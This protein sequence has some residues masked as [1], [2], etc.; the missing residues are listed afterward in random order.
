[1]KNT[2]M[3]YGTGMKNQFKKQIEEMI[4]EGYISKRRHPE[5]DLYILNYTK[6]CQ[7]NW[8][9]NEATMTCRGLIV[10]EN[11]DVIARPFKKFFTM[12]QWRDLRSGFKHLTGLK[13]KTAFD[14]PFTVTEKMD[15]SLGVLF[16]NP[17][18][19]KWELSSR[20]SFESDQ[21]IRANKILKK[22]NTTLLDPS[23]TYMT[24]IVYPTNR[25]VVDYGEREMLC[26]LT[27]FHLKDG[28]EDMSVAVEDAVLANMPIAKKYSFSSF[29][30]IL[31]I[32]EDEG[33]GFVVRFDNGLR[34]KVKFEEYKRLHR[35]MTGITTP[36]KVW[37]MLLEEMDLDEV[38]KD[39]PVE[40]ADSIME[41]ANGLKE[42]YWTIYDHVK[43]IIVK[44]LV[45][46][47][48]PM[49]RKQ[50]ALK[51][52]DYKYKGVMFAILDNKEY[53]QTIWRLIRPEAH[54]HV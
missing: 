44:E 13:Y 16:W 54:Q 27:S 50:M 25:I 46:K 9:W 43:S 24:E 22:Y 48:R 26:M 52:Q 15:G 36:R 20:G 5:C 11:W 17:F 32:Q 40:F 51:Y 42:E 6:K 14:G 38:L 8:F 3:F 4:A 34:V 19:S 10:D 37:W 49:S 2:H 45:Q 23:F 47:K 18:L 53:K 1:M 7:I 29:D 21:A 30:E 41:I 39:V 35:I 12:E 33:E 28:V 31:Q